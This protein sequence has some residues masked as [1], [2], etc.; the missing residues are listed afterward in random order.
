MYPEKYGEAFYPLIGLFLP[1][2]ES[3][4]AMRFEIDRILDNWDEFTYGVD[5]DVCVMSHIRLNDYQ[6]SIRNSYIPFLRST[7]ILDNDFIL[8]DDAIIQTIELKD[9]YSRDTMTIIVHWR[10]N[11]IISVERAIYFPRIL[12]RQDSW[13]FS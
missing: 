2:F 9:N 12:W 8:L 6:D 10:N 7:T 13:R 3:S 1:S 5:D 11:E 4:V